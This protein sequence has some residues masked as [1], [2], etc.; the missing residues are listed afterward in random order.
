MSVLAVRVLE[1]SIEIASDSLVTQYNSL[2]SEFENC[3][4]FKISDNFVI[5]GVGYLRDLSLIKMYAMDH[6]PSNND[7]KNIFLYISEYVEYIR[8]HYPEYD[9][10][11]SSYYIIYN[12]KCYRAD[13]GY[14]LVEI[15]DVDAMGSGM[16]PAY[17]VL[18]MGHDVFD[19]VEI[20]CKVNPYCGGEIV[21][22]E[23]EI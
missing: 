21:K 12:G 16:E 4:L 17:A 23:V 18:L 1:N 13:G 3:K 6:K 11:E 2:Q 22:Y 5:G 10:I 8:K 20:A 9:P 7:F 19:A 15:T 14:D